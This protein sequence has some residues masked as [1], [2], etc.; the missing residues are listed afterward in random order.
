MFI[1]NICVQV[2]NFASL[3][4]KN[5]NFLAIDANFH[6]SPQ[7]PEMRVFGGNPSDL[8]SFYHRSSFALP[9]YQSRCKVGERGEK[10][11]VWYG[12][13][14]KEKRPFKRRAAKSFSEHRSH[15]LKGFMRNSV[16]L[17]D[18]NYQSYQSFPNK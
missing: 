13:R 7:A 15:R 8:C 14:A 4:S 16:A 2:E 1:T 3:R 5:I 17:T 9:P 11:R 10:Q 6:E 12:G 18:N